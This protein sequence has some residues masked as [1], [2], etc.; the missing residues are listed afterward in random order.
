MEMTAY[1]RSMHYETGVLA[2]SLEIVAPD[3][4][5]ADTLREI[6]PQETAIR[7]A[8]EG[9]PEEALNGLEDLNDAIQNDPHAF[10]EA[11]DSGDVTK[12]QLIDSIK[13]GNTEAVIDGIKA[14]ASAPAAPAAAAPVEQQAAPADSPKQPAAQEA[15][16]QEGTPATQAEIDAYNDYCQDFAEKLGKYGTKMAGKNPDNPAAQQLA[17]RLNDPAVQQ[18]MAAMGPETMGEMFLNIKAG[19][20]EQM[21]DV[22]GQMKIAAGQRALLQHI[23]KVQQAREGMGDP[24]KAG[25]DAM[26]NRAGEQMGEPAV[27]QPEQQPVIAPATPKLDTMSMGMN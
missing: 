2:R 24:E 8:Q 10:K 21:N 17:E 20:Y 7:F 27:V 22:A 26:I 12:Q 5:E 13:N 19:L 3:Q 14:H 1:V 6:N 25:N 15:K 9:R 23:D 16:Q 18:E 11:I 4:Y